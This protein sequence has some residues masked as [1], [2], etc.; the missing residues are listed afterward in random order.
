MTARGRSLAR[1]LLAAAAAAGAASAQ[2]WQPLGPAP[3][4]GGDFAGFTGRV[5]DVA[6]SRHDPNLYFAAAASGGVWRSGDG[7]ASWSPLTDH[8]PTTALGDRKSVV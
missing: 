4:A 1:V 7:G 2:E 6:L 5:A 8:L 3:I